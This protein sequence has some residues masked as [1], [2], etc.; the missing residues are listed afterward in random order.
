MAKKIYISVSLILFVFIAVATTLYFVEPK[1]NKYVND[2]ILNVVSVEDYNNRFSSITELEEELELLNLELDSYN[3]D[4]SDL[5][6]SIISLENEILDL[7]AEILALGDNASEIIVLGNQILALQE[8]ILELEDEIESLNDI[9]FDKNQRIYSLSDDLDIIRTF[10]Y[11]DF[12][13]RLEKDHTF[14][15]VD[16]AGT[17]SVVIV[18]DSYLTLTIKKVDGFGASGYTFPPVDKSNLLNIEKIVLEGNVLI[19]SGFLSHFHGCDNLREIVINSLN[20]NMFYSG[21]GFYFGSDP[22]YTLSNLEAI[23]VPS[24]VLENYKTANIFS[25]YADIIFA[26]E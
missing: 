16:Y 13:L 24:Q 21:D 26:I 25:N 3:S 15:V 23:Y 6:N 19:G 11:G 9:I 12:K 20:Y 22:F 1:T 2:N 18:P 10:Y 7:E 5:E 4:V 17:D 8:E 14:S